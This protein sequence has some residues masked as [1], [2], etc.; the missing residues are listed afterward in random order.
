VEKDKSK[1]RLN[2]KI[3]D[4][5]K[6][7]LLIAGMISLV[8]LLFGLKFYLLSKNYVSDKI[9]LN[10]LA[11]GLTQNSF[12]IFIEGLAASIIIDYL[13]RINK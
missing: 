11:Q 12:Y 7:I 4:I 2:L 6:K 3:S 8:M 9:D 13:T 5:S 10:I 1:K